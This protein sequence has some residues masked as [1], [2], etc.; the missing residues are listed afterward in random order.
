MW[1]TSLIKK[2][3]WLVEKFFEVGKT[4]GLGLLKMKLKNRTNASVKTIKIYISKSGTK[5]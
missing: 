2:K 3:Y 4:I 5:T 1:K